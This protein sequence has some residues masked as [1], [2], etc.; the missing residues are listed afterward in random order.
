[1]HGESTHTQVFY[2]FDS[3]TT[4][5][6]AYRAF[7][8]ASGLPA[9]APAPHRAVSLTRG[10]HASDKI[11]RGSETTARTGVEASKQRRCSA[12]SNAARSIRLRS[13]QGSA[14]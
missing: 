11:R 9:A 5:C 14:R 12:L 8:V 1:M 3:S 4:G 13:S 10:G 7:T 2:I 6:L